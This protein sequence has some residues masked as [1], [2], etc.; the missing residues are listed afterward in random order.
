[1][2][3]SARWVATCQEGST[4]W[5]TYWALRVSAPKRHPRTDEF[6]QVGSVDM[7]VAHCANGVEPLL[8]RTIPQDVWP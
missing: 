5:R 3:V 1:M 2:N 8:V 6:I 4:T 7:L